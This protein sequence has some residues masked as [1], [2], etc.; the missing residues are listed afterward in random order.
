[1]K[2]KNKI[3]W[4][5]LIG[6]FILGACIDDTGNY[7]YE[8]PDRILPIEISGLS[9]TTFRVLSTVVLKPEVKGIE[10]EDDYWFTWYTYPLSFIRGRDTLATTRDLTFEMKY[11]AGEQHRLVYEIKEKRTGL[12]VNVK[13]NITGV[14]DFTKGWFVLNDVNGE[15]DIDFVFPDGT[16]K[17]DILSAYLEKKLSGNAVK[18]FYQAGNYI[19]QINNPDGT[20]TIQKNKK[21]LHV[22][23]TKDMVTL[24]PDNMSVYKEFKD[25]FYEDPEVAAPQEIVGTKRDIYLM[26]GGR[27]HTIY[28]MSDHIGKFGFPKFQHGD[29]Y[30]KMLLFTYG[31]SNVLSFSRETKSFVMTDTWGSQMNELLEAGDNKPVTVSPT[32]MNADLITLLYRGEDSDGVKG[33]ALMKNMAGPEEYYLA[34]INWG[35][36]KRYPFADFDTISPNREFLHADVYGA[37]QLNNFYFAKGNVLSYYQKNASDKDSYEKIDLYPF[38]AGETITFIEQVESP[39]NSKQ[40]FNHLVVITNSSNGWKLYRFELEGEGISPNILPGSQP[41][42]YSGKGTARYAKYME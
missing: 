29:L 19:H 34:D 31:N 2:I 9:D 36:G 40:P 6:L 1:M 32:H 27:I 35:G 21:A 10:N 30:P 41:I 37:H 13:V 23:S 12:F 14:S 20:V 16:V 3:Y 8:A 7:T 5:S 17:E 24:N 38:P 25:E 22:L 11:P 33:W 15:T 42:V 4:I 26:N 28:G 39:W 18:I